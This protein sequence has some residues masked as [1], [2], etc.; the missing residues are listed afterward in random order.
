MPRCFLIAECF[1]PLTDVV[2]SNHFI[3]RYPAADLAAAL[4]HLR[5]EACLSPLFSASR[6]VCWDEHLGSR[7]NLLA[8]AF[9]ASTSSCFHF[10]HTCNVHLCLLGTLQCNPAS[11]ILGFPLDFDDFIKGVVALKGSMVVIS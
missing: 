9:E 4:Q 1:S 10:R 7:E 5:A 11:G 2:G 6:A 3:C 8:A